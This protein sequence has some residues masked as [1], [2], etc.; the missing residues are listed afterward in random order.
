MV[1]DGEQKAIFLDE[2]HLD[3]ASFLREL[4]CIVQQNQQM[5]GVK[6]LV[7]EQ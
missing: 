4:D 3:D 5:V 2:N 1:G 7:K 6:D